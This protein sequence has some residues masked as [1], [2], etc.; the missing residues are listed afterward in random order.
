MAKMKKMDSGNGEVKYA[1]P[2]DAFL[3]TKS[4]M[5]VAET[6]LPLN[7][8]FEIGGKTMAVI[9]EDGKGLY[10]TGKNMID[11][12]LLDPFRQ[13]H[14]GKVIITKNEPTKEGEKPS[15]DIEYNGN[16]YSHV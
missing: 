12:N 8:F 7:T 10:L 15:F 11:S 13:Y 16:V 6:N 1:D 9:A 3:S 2:R 14:R 5:V 4:N